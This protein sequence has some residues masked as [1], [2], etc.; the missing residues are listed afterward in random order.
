MQQGLSQWQHMYITE[1]WEGGQMQ[2]DP[3]CL[4]ASHSNQMTGCRFSDRL[5]LKKQGEHHYLLYICMCTPPTHTQLLL[6]NFD[7]IV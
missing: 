5:C 7:F 4:L 1:H 6:K 2:T 3:R